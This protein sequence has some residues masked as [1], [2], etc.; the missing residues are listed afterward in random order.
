M[1]R[2][3]RRQKQGPVCSPGVIAADVSASTGAPTV[4]ILV[5][6]VAT[7]VVMCLLGV[8][9]YLARTMRVMRQAA[10]DLRRE[11]VALLTE[12]RGAIGLASRDLERADGLLETAESISA[13]VDSASRQA[14]LTLSRP[15]VKVLAFGTGT[16][17]AARRL[18]RATREG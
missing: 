3:A 8:V 15:V 12:M 10:D 6:I 4:A 5:T 13:T 11:S 7:V 1:T 18:R 16:R 9:W 14:Y 17:K 2:A